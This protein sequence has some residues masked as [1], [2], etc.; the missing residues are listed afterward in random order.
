MIKVKAGYVSRFVGR[1]VA[2]EGVLRNMQQAAVPLP[3][4]VVNIRQW[5]AWSSGMAGMQVQ[6]SSPALRPSA[7]Q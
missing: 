2:V 6:G 1:Q 7:L 3:A 4:S 5:G